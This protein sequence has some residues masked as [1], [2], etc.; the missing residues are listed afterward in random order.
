MNSTEDINTERHKVA[1][2]AWLVTAAI[3]ALFVIAPFSYTA[4]Q[5]RSSNDHFDPVVNLVE[6]IGIAGGMSAIAFLVLAFMFRPSGKATQKRSPSV[7]RRSLDRGIMLTFLYWLL[8]I[9]LTST[10]ADGDGIMR[11]WMAIL[12]PVVVVSYVLLTSRGVQ[13]R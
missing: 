12:Y 2:Y 6:L 8:F 4:S 13:V 1:R 5:Q 9:A 3:T 10:G 7:V 11:G